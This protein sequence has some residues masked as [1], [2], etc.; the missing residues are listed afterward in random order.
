MRPFFIQLALLG[1]VALGL[2]RV[3]AQRPD[4]ILHLHASNFSAVISSEKMVLVNFHAPWCG[5]CK[6]LH[7][8]LVKVAAD[9]PNMNIEGRIASLD[10]SLEEHELLSQQEKIDGFPS[11]VLYRDGER[12]SEYLGSRTRLDILDFLRKRTG[13]PAVPI[14]SVQELEDHLR[15]LK[16][17]NDNDE[18]RLV[19]STTR[20]LVSGDNPISVTVGAAAASF[21]EN[22]IDGQAAVVLALF[23]PRTQD[24]KLGVYGKACELYLGLAAV[25]D[26]ARFLYADN[27]ALLQYFNI[28]ADT[29][30]VFT[31]RSIDGVDALIPVGEMPLKEDIGEAELVSHI[32]SHSLPLLI[33]YSKLT[34]PFINQIPIKKHVLLFIGKNERSKRIRETVMSVA[35]D[36]AFRGKFVFITIP[37]EEF[38]LVQ[39]FGLEPSGEYYDNMMR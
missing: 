2:I 15:V 1:L 5:Y 36:S 16:I 20:P 9:L 25:Y 32:V 7:I 14:S 4:E 21:S 11:I 38:Q 17:N 33:P 19:M 3:R 27:V 22:Y 26:Q 29:L 12:H 34:Q 24:S 23:V 18:E 35:I 30:L 31:D 39:Y 8:E 10:A 28:E 37:V 13:P 6:T